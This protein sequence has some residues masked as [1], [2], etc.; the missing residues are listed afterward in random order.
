M[1]DR[2]PCRKR[3]AGKVTMVTG[4]ASGIGEAT[5]RLFADHGAQVVVIADVQD[6]KGK[7]VAAQIGSQ[8]CTYIH[9]DVADENQVKSLVESTV[10]KYGRLDVMFSNA[11]IPG[12]G[13]GKNVLDLDMSG[14]DRVMEINARG[15][16][17]CVKHAARVMVEGGIKGSIVC[18]ASPA[19]S[20]G[21]DFFTEY[22]MSKHAVLGLMRCASR[23]LG[24]YGIRVNCITPGSVATP[25]SCSSLSKSVEEAEEFFEPC[26]Y[27]KCGPLKSEH[28]ADGVVF[29]ASDES[30]FVTGHNLA[31]DGGFTI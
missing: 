11:G 14:Y 30:A 2:Q 3:L 15:M 7:A 28:V 5:A 13:Y 10:Q 31:V 27:L 25:M 6:E 20:S 18:T 8:I 26:K 29:L 23:Q 24:K 4:G 1:A 17:V 9:C 19:A 16:A 22:T 21:S 12:D